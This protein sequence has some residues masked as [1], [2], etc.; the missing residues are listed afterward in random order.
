[1]P[2]KT[3]PP[4]APPRAIFV[5]REPLEVFR[6]PADMTGAGPKPAFDVLLAV[7]P[8]PG[9]RGIYGTFRLREGPPEYYACATRLPSDPKEVEDL[10][11]GVIPGGL[12]VRRIFLGDWRTMI[13]DIPGHFERMVEEYHH[14]LTR[15]SIECYRGTTELQLYLPVSDRAPRSPG[16]EAPRARARVRSGPRSS[17]TS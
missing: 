3:P 11:R 6:Y 8:R 7:L 2:R 12:Y 5:E 10:E 9:A 16:P 17:S 15:P 13:V 1:M 4:L 14:D